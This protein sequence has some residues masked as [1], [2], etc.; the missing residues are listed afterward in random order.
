MTALSTAKTA[1]VWGGVGFAA[2]TGVGALFGPAAAGVGGTF[3]NGVQISASTVGSSASWAG[4]SLNAALT[5]QAAAS[6]SICTS[7]EGTLACV[8]AA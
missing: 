7:A 1:V 3:M 2:M 8:P 5:P 6:T 4:N